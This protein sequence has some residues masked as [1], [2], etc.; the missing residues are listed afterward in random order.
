MKK[1][2]KSIFVVAVLIVMMFMVAVPAFASEVEAADEAVMAVEESAGEKVISSKA[3]AAAV[4]VGIACAAGAV[5]M[6]WAI[7]KS[8]DGISRQPEAE[9]KIRT[10]MMLGLIFVETVIIYALVVAILI[11]FVL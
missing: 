1:G 2:V 6:A 3:I 11:I 9:G 5:G 10:T 4:V 8:V 7:V